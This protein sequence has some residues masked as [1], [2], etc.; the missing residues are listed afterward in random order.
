MGVAVGVG[1]GGGGVGVGGGDRA[2]ERY[3]GDLL[4]GERVMLS[5][6]RDDELIS[7]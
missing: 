2:V 4:S 7:V 3:P 6:K 5:K 1:V